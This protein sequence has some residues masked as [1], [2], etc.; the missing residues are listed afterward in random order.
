MKKTAH[1]NPLCSAGCGYSFIVCQIIIMMCFDN[2]F[3]SVSS[4]PHRCT[5]CNTQALDLTAFDKES[6]LLIEFHRSHCSQKSHVQT[7]RNICC[8]TFSLR[9][10]VSLVLSR[11][12]IYISSVKW[13]WVTQQLHCITLAGFFV[14][15]CI[16]VS[17]QDEIIRVTSQVNIASLFKSHFNVPRTFTWKDLN[18]LS[19]HSSHYMVTVYCHFSWLLSALQNMWCLNET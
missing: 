8:G 9:Y 7:S 10:I 15:A 3:S 12:S 16:S 4:W 1:K 6:S 2:H 13:I 5:Q 18:I 17:L 11:S 19:S 14:A